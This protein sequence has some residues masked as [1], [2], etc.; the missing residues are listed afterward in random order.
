VGQTLVIKACAQRD[1]AHFY[2]ALNLFTGVQ[3][4]LRSDLMSADVSALFLQ[5]V[6]MPISFV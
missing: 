6:W 5:Q 3:T 2:G 1:N 4:V